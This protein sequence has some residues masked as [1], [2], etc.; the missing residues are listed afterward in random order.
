MTNYFDQFDA[1]PVPVNSGGNFF[2]QF[3][4]KPQPSMISK[5]A[6]AIKNSD[7]V[8]GQEQR[9]ADLANAINNTSTAPTGN[10]QTPGETVYQ[11]GLHNIVGGLAQVPAAAIEGGINAV[12]KLPIDW[13]AGMS[14]E[15]IQR[16]QDIKSGVGEL[17]NA[18]N[19]NNAAYAKENPRAAANFQATRD[20]AN[21]IPLGSPEVKAAAGVIAPVAA[22]ALKSVGGDALNA[23]GNAAKDAVLY[24]PR[25]VT[26]ATVGA[27]AKSPEARQ[28]VENSLK[29]AATNTYTA[30]DDKNIALNAGGAQKIFDNI[31]DDLKAGNIQGLSGSAHPNT[32]S[33]IDELGKWINSPAGTPAPIPKGG[34][35][36][37]VGAIKTSGVGEISLKELDGY[38]RQLA[39]AS[40]SNPE[41]VRAA[42]IVRGA[43]DDAIHPDTSKIIATD[44]T[45]GSPEDM[46]LLK[47][48]QS[49]WATKSRYEDINTILDKAA[50]DPNKIKSGLT[51]YL[52]NDKNT[53]GW[54]A[55]ELAALKNAASGTTM[56]KIYKMGGKF[57]LDLGTSTTLG[58]TIGPAVAAVASGGI[59][60]GA[61]VVGGG[62][63]LRQLQKYMARGKAE[64]LLSVIQKGQIPKEVYNLPPPVAKN[65]IAQTKGNK[66]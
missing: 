54:P 40:Y 24:A 9:G 50:G 7:F 16:A 33:T 59:G 45:N 65:I 32:A 63:I 60:S 58:N 34:V 27:L 51:K 38:R 35:D 39:G 8:K 36:T 11:A 47:Q 56:E 2:D 44:L 22:D 3:D 46:G 10:Q 18:Y 13:T 19:Q 21:L 41:D 25:G 62:T 53:I 12:S 17:A 31:K 30:L 61:A 64:Q 23:A 37:G 52:E 28:A 49:Q 4:A 5:V 29:D 55:N 57:G 26:S 15:G 1:Q 6:D 14:P 66:P 43:L 20:L 48:A 42:A